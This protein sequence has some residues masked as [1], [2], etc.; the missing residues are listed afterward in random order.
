MSTFFHGGTVLGTEA[1]YCYLPN[2]SGWKVEFSLS[3]KDAK[4]AKKLD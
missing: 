1:L 4:T 3:K 2:F